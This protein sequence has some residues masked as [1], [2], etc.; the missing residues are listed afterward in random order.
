MVDSFYIMLT[1]K[2][3]IFF[4]RILSVKPKPIFILRHNCKFT[5]DQ[6]ESTGFCK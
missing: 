5:Y 3:L 6:V 2:L 1:L 4:N